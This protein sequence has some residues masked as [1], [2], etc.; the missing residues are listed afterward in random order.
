MTT[1]LLIEDHAPLRRNLSEILTLEGYRVLTAATGG[2]GLRLART[3]RPD[4][5]LCDIMLPG[6]DG[7]EILAALRGD[8]ACAG[9]P[10]IFLTAKGDAPDIRAGMKLGADDYLPKPVA[11]ADLLDAIRTRLQRASQQRAFPPCFDSPAPLETLGLSPR[12]AEVLL[13][14]A[15][16]KANHDIATILGCSHATVKKHAVHIFAK[17]GVE[18]RAAAMLIAIEALRAQ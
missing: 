13:W 2:D 10:F 1:L 15:Q 18:T 3:E 12:E 6:M 8:A 7:L 9:L 5:I 14:M 11:R 17:L 16:G 4:L